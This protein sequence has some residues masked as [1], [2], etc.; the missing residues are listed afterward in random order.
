MDYDVDLSN[1]A[2]D[3]LFN[4][5]RSRGLI[6]HAVGGDSDGILI[7]VRESFPDLPEEEVLE[8]GEAALE[9]MSKDISKY[10]DG[11]DEIIAQRWHGG[12]KAAVLAARQGPKP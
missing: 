6:V 4:E 9:L 7:E 1:V 3:A 12:V 5:L 10:F 8:I 11:V 2:E